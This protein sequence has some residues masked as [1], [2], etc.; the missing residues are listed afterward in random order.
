[1]CVLGRCDQVQSTPLEALEQQHV[2]LLT[3]GAA[4]GDQAEPVR[5]V[6][7]LKARGC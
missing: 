6:G 4:A 1:M 5:L 2:A 7:A 3:C